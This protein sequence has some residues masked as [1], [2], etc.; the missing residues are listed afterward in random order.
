V[1]AYLTGRYFGTRHYARIYGSFY[2]AY[3]LSG[4]LGPLA[5]AFV[6]ERHGYS[7]AMLCL[8]GMLAVGCIMLYRFPQ[9]APDGHALR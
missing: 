7:T 8:A 3:S 6:A 9:F 2:G 5:T 1:L 4:G